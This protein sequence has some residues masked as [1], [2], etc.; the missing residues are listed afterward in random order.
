MKNAI[1]TLA[2]ILALLGIAAAG[3]ANADSPDSSQSIDAG[4][5]HRTYVLHVPAGLTGRVPL[6]LAFHGHGGNGAGMARLTGLDALA[7]R[8]QFIVAYPDGIDRG[9]NDGRRVNANGANDLAFAAALQ[10]DLEKRYPIDPNRVYVTGF[11]NG[12][13]FANYLSCSQADRIAAFAPVSGTLP[14][15]DQA[16]CHP[17][18]AIPELQIGGTADPI[19]PFSGGQIV[20]LGRD[21][22]EVLSADRNAALWA[23]NAGCNPKPVTAPLPPVSPADGTSVTRTVFTGCRPGTNVVQYSV[24]GGGHTWPDGR[25]YLTRAIIGI[26]SNQLD[27]SDTIV[28]FFL[29]HQR[30]RA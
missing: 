12:A 9:W 17:Q 30:S 25:P 3:C 29:A 26:T 20:L 16:G 13:T 23:A 10:D 11:S 8:Y 2:A 6:I 28:R 18:R 4:G 24:I 27:A 22:G 5:A 21:R 7:D 14:A 15:V 1:R 19:M